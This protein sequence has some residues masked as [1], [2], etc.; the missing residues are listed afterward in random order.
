MRLEYR[1]ADAAANP[2]L[3]LGAILA[4]GL[5]G[6]AAELPAPPILD[7]DPS[8]LD[9]EEAERYGVG[10]L[11][12]TL[13]EALAALAEDRVLRGA[14]GEPLYEAFVALK[15]AELALV[16]ELPLER[17]LPALR[18]GL[19]APCS[20]SCCRRSKR[21]S[22]TPSSCA[23]ACTPTP[24]WRTPSTAPRRAVAAELPVAARRWP[25]QD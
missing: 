21:S 7:R 6:I 25:G 23:G 9:D 12:G 3:A 13:D 8:S 4:A 20:T 5:D 16:A 19:L 15:R 18:G 14:L 10:A 22:E 1:G 2:H 11:P 24:S 17:A